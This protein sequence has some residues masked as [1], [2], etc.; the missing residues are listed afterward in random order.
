MKNYKNCLV[1]KLFIPIRSIA[2]IIQKL[3]SPDCFRIDCF[4]KNTVIQFFTPMFVV[5]SELCR[6]NHSKVFYG[7]VVLQKI[8]KITEKTCDETRLQFQWKP[9]YIL[10]V[11][12]LLWQN[13]QFSASKEHHWMAA[14]FCI[15]LSKWKIN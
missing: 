14:G 3:R 15:T 6:S 11:F 4:C 13:F 10:G 5:W 12:A 1:F 8:T 7:M 2:K 9:N